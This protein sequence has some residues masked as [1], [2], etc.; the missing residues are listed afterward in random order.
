MYKNKYVFIYLLTA[1]VAAASCSKKELNV[2]NPNSPTLTSNVTS[3]SGLIALAQGGVYVNGFKNGDGWLGDSY[4]SLP[5][6]YAELMGDVVG[7]DA[8]NQQVTTI[9][10]PDYYILDNGTKTT[11]GSPQIS[12]IRTYNL[13]GGSTNNPLYYQWLNMYALNAACNTVLNQISTVTFSGDATSRANTIKAWCYWWK[14]YAYAQIGTMYYSGLIADTAIATKTNT[15]G[16]YVLNTA[17]IARSN[18]FLN[19]AATTLSSI[20]SVSDFTTELTQLVPAACQVG[21]G[22]A[23]TSTA[24]WQ[25]NIN[26]MLARNILLNKLAPFVNN[27]PA[28]TIAKSSTTAMTT[29]DWN[30]VLTLVTNGIQSSDYV[31]TARSVASNYIFSPTGGTAAALTTGNNTSS[32]FKISERFMQNFKATDKRLTTDFR[33]SNYLNAFFGTRYAIKDSLQQSVTGVYVIASKQVGQYEAFIAG[34]Y[35]ENQMMLAE[36]NIRLGNINT[37][38]AYVDAVRTYQ[39]AGVAAVANTGL[40]LTQALKELTSERRVSL[41]FRG[42]SFYDSRR[43]GWT[44]DISNGGGSYGNNLYTV[45]GVLNTNVTIDYD[46][47]DYW[48]VPADESVLNPPVAGAAA[49]K[50]PNF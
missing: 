37:G 19:L 45:A 35:E 40:T 50:N 5:Y 21:H 11:N 3:E 14:G 25:R 47:L 26:T 2:G 33:P 15:S 7:A 30:S 38:L 1:I 23:F 22:L 46:F 43:W 27:N 34:S 28:A 48:D 42:L 24:M 36:A 39:G 9:G 18:Y 32:T 10:N 12:V 31:F 4:F 16:N 29:A 44:Y 17:V 41:V 6:G 49:V 20:T 8:T 13:Y